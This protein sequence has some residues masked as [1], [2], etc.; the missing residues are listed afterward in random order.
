M[1][2]KKITKIIIIIIILLAV[3]VSAYFGLSKKPTVE[4]TTVKVLRG[5]LIQTVSETGTIK[6]S[7]EINLNFLNS[8]RIAKILVKT[9]DNVKKDQILAELDFSN[10]SIKERE[11]RANLNK[12]TAGATRTEIAVSEA[13]VNQAFSAYTAAQSEL[14]KVKN[15]AEENITQAEKTLDDLESDL[16][17]D[18][19]VYEQ[20]ILAAETSLENTKKTYQ[21]SISNKE[22]I[23]LTTIGAELADGATALDDINTII[24]DSD[25]EGALSVKNTSYLDAAKI[26]RADGVLLL[27]T[28]E[29]SLAIAKAAK[30]EGNTD[31]AFSD[32]KSALDKTFAS[33]N[34]IYD[35]LENSVT[36]SNFTQAELDAYKTTTSADLTTISASISNLQTANQNL[37]DARLAYDTNVSNSEKALKKAQ[38]DYDNAVINGR[39]ALNTARISGDQQITAAEA[40]INSALESWQVAK[41]QLAKLKAPARSEDI[42]LQQTALDSVKKQIEDSIIKAPIDG[43]VTKVNYEIGEQWSAAEPVISLLAENNFEIEVDI[44]EADIAKVNVGDKAEITLDAFGDD[45]K[46]AGE[47][48]FL[49]PAETVIQDVVYYKTKIEFIDEK[50]VAQNIKPGMT[51][52]AVITTMEKKN[53]LI[54]PARAVVEKNGNGRIVRVLVNGE[55]EEKPVEVGLRGDEGMVEVLSGVKEGDE[56]VTFVKTAN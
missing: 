19:T 31:K 21:K 11:A 40:K 56:V 54:M 29:N 53:V 30:T 42:I 28:A 37:D 8:G 39:N 34:N 25:T 4:Y 16:P 26:S 38:V 22:D 24:N 7:S 3:G 35:A 27:Q 17:G 49:E 32:A 10:L 12:L 50:K 1:F 45:V 6:A 43:T 33:L 52:N 14:E 51:A 36:S 13:N 55:V 48:S 41:A 44:S 47:V 46:F 9:G 15:T 20:A 5:D 18:I 23:I 2:K